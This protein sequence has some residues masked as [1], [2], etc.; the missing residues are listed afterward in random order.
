MRRRAV[1]VRGL[2]H[3][4]PQPRA[5]QRGLR[6]RQ[7][8]VLAL[9]R[10]GEEAAGAL[11]RSAHEVPR[12]R[13]LA[14]RVALRER[15][16]ERVMLAFWEREIDVLVC[17]TI[18]ESGLDVPNANTLIVERA[19]LLGLAQLHQLRG[20]VGR[21]SE[22]GYAYL[23]H[24]AGAEMTELAHERLSVIAERSRLGSGLAIA[25]R[26]LELR[27]AGNV[28]GADQSGHVAA[29]GLETY[30]ELLR[31]E[32]AELSGEPI[33]LEPEVTLDLPVDANLPH[34][35]VTDDDVRLDLYR[36]I[37]AV[38]DARGV[39]DVERELTDRFGP[40][41]PATVRLLALA[42]LKAALLRAGITEVQVTGRGRLRLA[43]VEPSA[44]VLAR[45]EQDLPG[46]TW[47]PDDRVLVVPLPHRRPDDLVAWVG[48]VVRA[49]RA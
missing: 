2:R 32:V 1:R 47:R 44:E 24:P 4:G 26:D 37:A 8:A 15:E 46:T 48:G 34:D 35:Y 10:V 49:L 17:T 39:G 12:H 38:R 20:R 31:E 13:D 27:G 28:I 3:R 43:P 19:D 11:E 16:L 25:M 42:A 5:R 18:I 45:L 21:S 29:V 9:R 6:K 30:A 33:A 40:P 22:R 36:R 14:R 7:R 23:L 41:P